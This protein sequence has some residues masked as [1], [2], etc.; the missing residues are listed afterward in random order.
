MPLEPFVKPQV[1][2][3]YL[4][5]M[6]PE[7]V[8]MLREDGLV[9]DC[10][11]CGNSHLK[12]SPAP[13]MVC[14]C[15]NTVNQSW[16]PWVVKDFTPPPGGVIQTIPVILNK[17][18]RASD[19]KAEEVAKQLG[20]SRSAFYRA[21]AGSTRL[22]QSAMVML[23]DICASRGWPQ[24]ATTV[25][26]Y[27]AKR[28]DPYNLGAPRINSTEDMGLTPGYWEEKAREEAVREHGIAP[29]PAYFPPGTFDR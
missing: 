29:N 19:N 20:I 17:L 6:R 5:Y 9:L 15:G 3:G 22:R 21:M 8:Q 14:P 18:Y 12:P 13:I 11:S 26:G 16:E 7:C 2:Q 10:R 28:R 4:C 24:E 25:S 1:L 27:W 23:G